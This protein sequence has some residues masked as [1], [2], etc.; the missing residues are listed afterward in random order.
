M[1]PVPNG[2][3]N[4]YI[5]R[6]NMTIV[7]SAAGLVMLAFGSFMTFQNAATDRRITDLK[8][9]LAKSELNFLRK[10][11]H[12]E[13]KYRI[14]RDIALIRDE[15]LR[16]GTAIVPRTEHEARWKSTDDRTELLASNIKLISERL[17]ELRTATSG[18][19]TTRDEISRLHLELS[20][21]RRQLT[22][23]PLPA[24]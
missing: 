8:E 17:N 20:E 15:Q 2:T 3:G 12:I 24:R 9:E 13:F 19:V 10:D 16:R 4:G 7:M 11:E 14:D 1:S 22:E 23:R 21:L 5:S 18:T 6:G